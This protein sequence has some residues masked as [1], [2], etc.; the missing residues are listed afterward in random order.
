MARQA[1]P[2]V[3][4][5]GKRSLHV[6]AARWRALSAEANTNCEILHCLKRHTYE[7]S[8]DCWPWRWPRRDTKSAPSHPD[9]FCPASGLG[10]GGLVWC[11]GRVPWR[12]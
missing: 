3:A 8:T 9:P 7:K 12:V 6:L 11:W 10:A 2:V 1:P 5:E 4:T